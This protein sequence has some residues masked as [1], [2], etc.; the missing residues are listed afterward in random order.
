MFGYIRLIKNEISFIF[1]K[2]INITSDVIS[3]ITSLATGNISLEKI[4]QGNTLKFILAI[5]AI[6][7]IGMM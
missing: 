7:L 6:V 2:V 4:I 5:C 1:S 3:T